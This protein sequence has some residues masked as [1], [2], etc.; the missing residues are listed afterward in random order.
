[1]PFRARSFKPN[2]KETPIG[3]VA[4]LHAECKMFFLHEAG[5]ELTTGL[6]HP[7]GVPDVTR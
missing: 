1:V 6:N 3:T 5:L 2:G 4:K 7:K